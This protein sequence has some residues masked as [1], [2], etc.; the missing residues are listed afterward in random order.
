MNGLYFIPEIISLV[1]NKQVELCNSGFMPTV[2][3]YGNINN[4]NHN[5]TH[6]IDFYSKARPEIKIDYS[7]GTSKLVGS[8]EIFSIDNQNDQIKTTSSKELSSRTQSHATSV[9]TT[10]MGSNGN[11][12]SS[13]E[14]KPVK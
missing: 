13:E 1:Q 12:K 2:D 9:N 11:P 14:L 4:A 8:N 6:I 5:K 3:S 7:Q 10:F